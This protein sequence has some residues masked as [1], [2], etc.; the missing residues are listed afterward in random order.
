MSIT[1][2]SGIPRVTT[3]VVYMII[4]GVLRQRM[5]RAGVISSTILSAG[6]PSPSRWGVPLQPCRPP[7]VRGRVWSPTRNSSLCPVSSGRTPAY[8]ARAHYSAPA[9]RLMAGCMRSHLWVVSSPRRFTAQPRISLH[10]HIHYMR[11]FH[12]YLLFCARFD[13]DAASREEQQN[14]RLDRWRN[15]WK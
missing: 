10:K 2:M 4:I 11:P 3:I 15:I 6:A 9:C 14:R 13:G 1:R 8:S 12:D 5:S 7:T